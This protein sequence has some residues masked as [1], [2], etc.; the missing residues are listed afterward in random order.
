MH[1]VQ[2]TSLSHLAIPSSC[3]LLGPQWKRETTGWRQGTDVGLYSRSE[4]KGSAKMFFLLSASCHCLTPAKLQRSAF[5]MKSTGLMQGQLHFSLLIQQCTR[6]TLTPTKETVQCA[7]QQA[8]NRNLPGSW[9]KHWTLKIKGRDGKFK[10]F[11]HCERKVM[12][13]TTRGPK[14]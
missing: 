12:N 7:T 1:Q 3:L 6:G 14:N 8:F 13:G 5:G 2:I 10:K 4:Q 9:T 11:I